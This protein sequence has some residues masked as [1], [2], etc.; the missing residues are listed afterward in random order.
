M[1]KSR[2]LFMELR[3]KE[4]FRNED[5]FLENV[6]MGFDGKFNWDYLLPIFGDSRIAPMDLD[7]VVER[8][9]NFLVME[10]KTHSKAIPTGQVRTLFALHK[11]GG[12]TILAIW[13]RKNKEAEEIELVGI[14]RP[15][16]SKSTE[17][18][19]EMHYFNDGEVGKKFVYDLVEKWWKFA[20]E[21]KFIIQ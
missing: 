18:I 13:M 15:E 11:R 17:R 12:F 8:N 1:S 7:G 6:P 9:D 10:T 14:M 5:E 21:N 19:M 4:M 20:N 3:E 16:T 2:E